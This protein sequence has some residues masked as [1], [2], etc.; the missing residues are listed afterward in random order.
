MSR[1]EISFP[2]STQS[3][4]NLR[5]ME[6]LA[7]LERGTD[8]GF[9]YLGVLEWPGADTLKK[10]TVYLT[11]RDNAWQLKPLFYYPNAN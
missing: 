5:Q 4:K 3:A 1:I 2:H 7:S 10:V 11:I 8:G 6:N 9:F